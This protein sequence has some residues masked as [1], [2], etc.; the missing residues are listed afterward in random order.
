SCFD[1]LNRVKKLPPN[2][3]LYPLSFNGVAK[4]NSLYSNL[5]TEAYYEAAE[6]IE[7][8]EFLMDDI[9]DGELISELTKRKTS[10]EKAGKH[11]LEIESKESYIKR[12][13][14][15]PNRADA[16]VLCLYVPSGCGVV[17]KAKIL[18]ARKIY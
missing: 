14:R 4:K 5:I 16:Y 10:I 6:I 15:S 18:P 17:V 12:M 8:A 13:K 9:N 7:Q 3:H 2:V 1:I 11:R